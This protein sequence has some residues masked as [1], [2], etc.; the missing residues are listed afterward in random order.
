MH[1]TS[2]VTMLVNTHKLQENVIND[3]KRKK[4]IT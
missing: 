4:D 3:I 2:V 1:E